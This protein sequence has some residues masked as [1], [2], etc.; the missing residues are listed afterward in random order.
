M[1]DNGYKGT[2]F[3]SVGK[4][5]V[6]EKQREAFDYLSYHPGWKVG[7]KTLKWQLNDDDVK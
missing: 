4:P 5:G 1:V 2:E 7:E 6:R 3:G